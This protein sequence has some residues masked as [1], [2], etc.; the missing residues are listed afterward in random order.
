MKPHEEMEAKFY[1]III[2][3]L[4]IGIIFGVL[5]TKI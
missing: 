4:L 3:A 5:I 1:G 2:F